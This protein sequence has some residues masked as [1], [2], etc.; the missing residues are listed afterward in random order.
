MVKREFKYPQVGTSWLRWGYGWVT[1]AILASLVPPPDFP[2]IEF[3][4]M[5]KFLHCLMYAFLMLWFT[6]IYT[7]KAFR[8][9][10]LYFMAMGICL[11]L[12]QSLTSYRSMEIADMVANTAGVIFGWVLAAYG[13]SELLHSW[14]N[15]RFKKEFNSDSI[16]KAGRNQ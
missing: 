8:V 5:D 3:V 16:F 2:I 14:T 1:L 15:A 11:E 9:L 12:L 6:Q 7:Q 4:S 10:A 13:L